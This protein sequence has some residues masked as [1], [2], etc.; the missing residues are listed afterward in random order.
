MKHSLAAPSA[1]AYV[2]PPPWF[3]NAVATTASAHFFNCHGIQLHYRCWNADE[4]AKPVLLFVHGYKGN[5][6][7]WDFIAPY[8]RERFRVVAMD[9]AGMGESGRRS[10]YNT[11]TFTG[12][13]IGVLEQ[14]DSPAFVVA[15]S[16]GG[17]RTLRVAADRPDLIRHAVILDSCIRF[18]DVDTQPPRRQMGSGRPYASYSE[19]RSHYRPFPEQPVGLPDALE[20]IA[21]YAIVKVGNAWQWHFDPALPTVGKEIYEPDGGAILDRVNTPVDFIYGAASVVVEP[22]R[23]ARTAAR[24]CHCRGPIVLPECHHHLMLDQPLALVA[25]LRALLQ[26]EISP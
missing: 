14:F 1:P 17:G 5:S 10:H 23:A 20:H 8:F 11:E 2:N 16:Y 15:H 26:P 13:L 4:V 6:H 9:F 25:A 3:L 12:D 22:W 21:F 19:A 7:W 18:P 24:L